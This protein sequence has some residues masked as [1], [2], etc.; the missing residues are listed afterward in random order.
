MSEKKARILFVDDEEMLRIN[1]KQLLEYEGYDVDAVENGIQGIQRLEEQPYDLVITDLMMPGIDGIGVMKYINEHLPNTMVILITGYASIESAIK[2][3]RQ[4]A[5]DYVTK[6][7]DFDFLKIS[8][9]KALEKIRLKRNL[10]RYYEH[11]EDR[12][13]DRTRALKEAQDQLLLTENLA[14]IGEIAAIV[15]HE[16]K[17]PLV[18]IGGVA[19]MLQRKVHDQ[20]KVEELAGIIVEEVD[21]LERILK[22]LLDLSRDPELALGKESLNELI[23]KTCILFEPEMRDMKIE[24]G[25]ELDTDLPDIFIDRDQIKQVVMNITKNA[26]HSMPDGGRIA[27]RTWAVEDEVSFAVSDTGDGISKENQDKLFTPFFSTKSWGT[28]LG[29]AV[30]QKLVANHGGRI[31]VESELGEGSTFTVTLLKGLESDLT[32]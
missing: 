23:R 3:V 2:A 10:K 7:L 32:S 8:I 13:R 21:R 28:G 29:L 25:F 5:Y 17:N 4:G 22:S 11:L 27:Y 20:E 15:A 12:I 30:S 31:E 14:A 6:P 19:R 26:I 18:S 1:V 16:I 9:Q 24:V